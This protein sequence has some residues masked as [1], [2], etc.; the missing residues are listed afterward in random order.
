MNLLQD[1]AKELFNMFLADAKLSSAILALV[2]GAAVLI[3]FDGLN[4]LIA[5]CGL[6]IGCLVILAVV[7]AVETKQRNRN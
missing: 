5:G 2:S 7:V 1:V 4:P 3:D 6:L